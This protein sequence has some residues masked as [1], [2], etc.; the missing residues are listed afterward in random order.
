MGALWAKPPP[1]SLRA[2]SFSVRS[3]LASPYLLLYDLCIL[4]VAAAFL[5]KDGLSR[6]FLPGE[7][8]AM[9]LCWPALFLVKMPIG[10]VVCSLIAFLCMRLI[11]TCGKHHP[12]LFAVDRSLR[13]VHAAEIGVA[14]VGD[15]RA[16]APML[17][18]I[19]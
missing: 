9:M 4:T 3:L 1:F 16:G 2:A 7:R 17:G 19:R 12:A 15:K 5:V 10:A 13:G 14:K 18:L 8:T 11:M 6:G